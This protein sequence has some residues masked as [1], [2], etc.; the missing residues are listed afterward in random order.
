MSLMKLVKFTKILFITA[1]TVFLFIG[2]ANADSMGQKELFFID[3]QF[4]PENQTTES[5]TLRHISDR[6]YFYIADNHWDR[7]SDRQRT[8]ILNDIGSLAAEFDNRI[9]PIERQ[10]FGSEPNPGID[11]NPRITL[12]LTN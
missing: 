5:A 7:L 6:A 2:T 4:D 12:F 10:F 11:N 3:P 9:Y 8:S 1:T